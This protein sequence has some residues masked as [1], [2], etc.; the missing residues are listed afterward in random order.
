L[1]SERAAAVEELLGHEQIDWKRII[2]TAARE[3]VASFLYQNLKRFSGYVPASALNDLKRIYLLNSARNLYLFQNALNVFTEIAGSGVRAVPIKG[4]RLARDL[5]S[6]IGLR[7]FVDIDLMVAHRD[8]ALVV[9]ILSRNGFSSEKRQI[10]DQTGETKLKFF[11]N[12]RPNY[13]KGKTWIELHFN[14][15][16]LHYPLSSKHLLWREA[17]IVE[18][19]GTSITCLSFEHEL[20]LLCLH[21]QEHSYSRLDWMTDIAEIATKVPLNWEKIIDFCDSE[22]IHASVYYALYLVNTIW[23]NTI[24]SLILARFDVSWWERRLSLSFWPEDRVRTRTLDFVLPMHIPTVFPLLR[25]KDFLHFFNVVFRLFFPPRHWV[26]Y[27]YGVPEN[28]IKMALHYFWRLLYPF[29]F[30]S[31]KVLRTG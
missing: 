26:A 23:P 8:K 17:G 19:E 2:K 4:F 10:S 15:P 24:S 22:K 14:I 9:D 3:G 5:Y 16:G 29:L 6:D 21:A 1:E 27:Y 11:W 31:R 12:Y 30:V 13:I 25:K 18:K 20:C 28:S 7:T